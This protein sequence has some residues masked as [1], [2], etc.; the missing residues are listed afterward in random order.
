MHLLDVQDKPAELP[1]PKV[2]RGEGLRQGENCH[3]QNVDALEKQ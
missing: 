1:P 2:R 3:I